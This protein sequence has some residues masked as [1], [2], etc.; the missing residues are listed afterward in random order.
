LTSG[1]ARRFELL[2]P[3][4]PADAGGVRVVVPFVAVAEQDGEA[5]VTVPLAGR[6]VDEEI[7]L[8]AELAMGPYPFRVP[9][10]RIVDLFDRRLLRLDTDF[11]PWRDGRRLLGADRVLLDSQDLGFNM[12]PDDEDG[13]WSWV[14]L[15]LP[16]ELPERVVVTFRYP[17]VA[18]AGP[19]RLRL[20][21][22][23]WREG[24]SSA[25]RAN[26][27]ARGDN[28]RQT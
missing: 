6:A 13:R 18:L 8:A 27:A 3:G 22:A 26:A 4:L 5:S 24:R 21:A 1:R 28:H 9:T 17:L 10:A 11:G 15:A 14:G 23:L 25:G 12:Q 2:F 19:W 16:P 20:P 7:L